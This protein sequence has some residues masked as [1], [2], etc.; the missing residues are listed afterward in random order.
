MPKK[1]NSRD[2]IQGIVT[3]I[4]NSTKNNLDGELSVISIITQ[5]L[6]TNISKQIITILKGLGFTKVHYSRRNRQLS[7]IY[8]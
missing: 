2:I 5:R 4:T 8:P 1:N 3:V 7:C 6:T